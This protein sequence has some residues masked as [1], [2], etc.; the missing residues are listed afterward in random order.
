MKTVGTLR[1]ERGLPVPNKEDSLY[2]V[3][4]RGLIDCCNRHLARPR[5]S[6]QYMHRFPLLLTVT[7]LKCQ[8]VS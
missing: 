5:N 2:R 8:A 4:S 3:S 6:P 1:F 7:E